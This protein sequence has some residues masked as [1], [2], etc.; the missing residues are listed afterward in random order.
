MTSISKQYESATHQEAVKPQHGS[1]APGFIYSSTSVPASNLKASSQPFIIDRKKS[2]LKSLKK[3]VIN[4]ARLHQNELL[5]DGT[6]AK[7]QAVFLTL[8]YAPDID[9]EPYHITGCMKHIRN[10]CD[11]RG[12]KCRYVW[13]AEIQESRKRN[14]GDGAGHCVHYHIMLWI[15]RSLQLPK[16]DKQG[17]W[18][19]GMTKTE[20]ARNA[21]GYIAKYASKGTDFDFPKGCRLHACGGLNLLSRL[22]RTWWSLPTTIRN[23]YPDKA[24][25]VRRALGGGWLDHP[26]GVWFPSLFKIIR[27]FPLTIVRLNEVSV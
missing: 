7:H 16:P 23:M 1:A 22:E 10:W 3:G 15:P 19:H 27:F 13:V 9:W 14:F 2:R 17:W 24:G 26:T 25:K 18:P 20:R 6:W 4:G 12:I 8:T 11:R 21:V 5:K